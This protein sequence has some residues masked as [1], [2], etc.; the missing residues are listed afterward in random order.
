MLHRRYEPFWDV[1]LSLA[2]PQ[3]KNGSISSWFMLNKMLP[4]SISD[5]LAAHTGDE[6]LQVLPLHL[7]WHPNT[8]AS[9]PAAADEHDMHTLNGPKQTARTEP[10]CLFTLQQY[11]DIALPACLPVTL[12]LR[13]SEAALLHHSPQ[14][15]ASLTGTACSG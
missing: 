14:C 5:C 10:A 4:A 12:H 9:Y 11:N 2:Q 7:A 15:R 3:G 8:G 6:L 13:V 1:S